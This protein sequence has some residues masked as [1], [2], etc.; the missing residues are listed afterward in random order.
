MALRLKDLPLGAFGA[1]MGLAGLGL[2]ARAAATVFPG[3]VRAPAYFTEL[4]VILGLA[5]FILLLAAFLAP[6]AAGEHSHALSL[7]GR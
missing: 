4:W 5:A 2:S 7:R 1:V 3:V 6:V